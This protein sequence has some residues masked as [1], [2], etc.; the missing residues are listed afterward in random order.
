MNFP[1]FV[2]QR[3]FKT[4]RAEAK[5]SRPA[6]RIAT[7]G[8]AIGLAV[9]IIAVSVVV[10]FQHTI[11]DK[12]VGFGSHITVGNFMSVTQGEHYP[13]V[14][15]D[16]I[17]SMMK[18]I[19]GVKTAQKYALKQGILKTDSDFLGIILKGVD[20]DFDTT[21]I[22]QNLIEG[23]LPPFSDKQSSNKIL[24]S[25]LIADKLHLKVGERVFA[26]FVGNNND[27]RT[28]RFTVVGIYETNLK[29]FDESLCL[30][31]FFTTQRLNAWDDDQAS[32]LEISISDF[33]NVNNVSAQVEALIDHKIDHNGETYLSS[34]ILK[35]YPQIFAWLKLLDLNIWVILALMVAIAGFTMISGLLIIILER[36]NMIGTLKAIG[37]TDGSIRAIFL[38]FAVFVIGRGLI[39]GNVV[40]I[41]I[42][43]LQQRFGLVSLDANVYYVSKAP[44][45]INFPVIALLNIATLLL[46]T[47]ILILPSLIVSGIHPAKTIRFE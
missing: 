27:V 30:T 4:N 20:N 31:D 36:T 17:V 43:Y 1:L 37:A 9:M 41:G 29:R 3:L 42:C 18:G 33:N 38:W 40:G 2:A 47:L 12:V 24:I 11:R 39:I 34:T 45:E 44:V 32:G 10:G 22:S 19:D 13:V 46:C 35:S 14:V 23:S 7:A 28:R 25:K 26:Y 8:V 5:I 6:V 15:N 16:S 21:F